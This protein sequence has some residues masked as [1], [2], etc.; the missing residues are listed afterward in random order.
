LEGEKMKKLIAIFAAVLSISFFSIPC[1]AA[2]PTADL[3]GDCFVDLE[4]FT[5]L[6]NQWL[7]GNHAT[8]THTASGT[9]TWD[10]NST[11]VLTTTTS[12]FICNGPDLGTETMT[13]VT[14][15]ATTMTWPNDDMTWTRPS[16]T[17]GDIVGTWTSTDGEGNS[18]TLTLNANNTVSV[19]GVI[20]QCDNNNGG[21]NNVKAE[22]QHWSGG[23]LVSLRY[24]DPNRT[25]TS[26]SVTGPGITGSVALTYNTHGPSWGSGTP[27]SIISFGTTYPDG[28]PFTYTFT[29]T[30]ATGT[31][32]ATSTISCFQQ[33]FVSNVSPTGSVTGTPTFSWTGIDDPSPVY[34]VQVNDSNGTWLWD[35]H[36]ISD[37]S[38]VY[39][40]P[41]LTPGITYGYVVS[42]QSSS[43]CSNPTSGG[44]SSVGDSFTYQQ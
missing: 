16:G 10:S 28:L 22:A 1:L 27:E 40:G 43:T 11:F 15:T 29:I 39:N 18:Y 2:C 36:F 23:Y 17:A 3:N 6:A 12:D 38:I 44:G 4:D 41:A 34:G 24:I 7:T 5:I 19:V 32:T 21:D 14:V 25:A 30:D 8:G 37:T 13:G 9:Y 31:W 33:Q 20:V 35:A 42:V 26:V